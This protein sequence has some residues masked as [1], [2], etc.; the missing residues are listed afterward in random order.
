MK[1]ALKA[2]SSRKWVALLTAGCL[3]GIG[4]QGCTTDNH[5]GAINP[6]L[7]ASSPSPVPVGPTLAPVQP[8]TTTPITTPNFGQITPPPVGPSLPEAPT[9]AEIDGFLVDQPFASNRYDVKLIGLKVRGTIA[10]VNVQAIN[11]TCGTD[12]TSV[13]IPDAVAQFKSS[14]IG[15]GNTVADAAGFDFSF[16][17]PTDP[18]FFEDGRILNKGIR[19]VVTG[20]DDEGEPET[21]DQLTGDDVVI[22]VTITD[23]YGQVL[24][25][26]DSVFNDGD[27]RVGYPNGS[28]VF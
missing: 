28:Y 25:L 18:A 19:E 6:L 9:V 13:L 27:E 5:D 15:R 8:G 3:A 23:S 14:L 7:I 4:L 12:V 17:F 11:I 22:I 16:L 1:M 20:F 26:D 21:E 24:R 10:N 2:S